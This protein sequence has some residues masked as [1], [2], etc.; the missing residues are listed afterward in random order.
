VD[1]HYWVYFYAQI[2]IPVVHFEQ[3][4]SIFPLP[5]GRIEEIFIPSLPAGRQ[6]LG[7]EAKNEDLDPY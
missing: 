5:K 2:Y 3:I 7:L 4:S 1:K 6:A